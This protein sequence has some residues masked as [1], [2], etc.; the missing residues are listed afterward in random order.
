MSGMLYLVKR[1]CLTAEKHGSLLWKNATPIWEV[2]WKELNFT[3][4][5]FI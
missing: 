5:T 1:G 3:N 4:R 2:R